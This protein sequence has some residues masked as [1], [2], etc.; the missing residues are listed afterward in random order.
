MWPMRQS[1]DSIASGVA[2]GLRAGW[3]AAW[4]R[5]GLRLER[6]ACG[7]ER[8]EVVTGG[9]WSGAWSGAT[10]GRVLR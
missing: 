10:A 8:A 7:L 5:G 4:E 9:A 6:V 3:P 2:C 1:S